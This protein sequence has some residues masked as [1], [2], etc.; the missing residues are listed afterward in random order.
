MKELLSTKFWRGVKKT[1][2][3]AREGTP[4]TDSSSQTPEQKANASEPAGAI[5]PV[6]TACSE[7]GGFL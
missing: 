2:D 4:S 5:A 3:E 1:F 6:Q 7:F